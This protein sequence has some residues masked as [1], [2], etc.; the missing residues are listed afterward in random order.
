VE[1]TYVITDGP[2]ER[3]TLSPM[4]IYTV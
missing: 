3:L 4:E 2:C 1:N